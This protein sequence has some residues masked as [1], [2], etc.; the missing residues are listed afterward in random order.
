MG[1]AVVV[2]ANHY[3]LDLVG[4][5]A[6]VLFALWVARPTVDLSRLAFIG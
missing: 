6:L 1:L 4:G 2:T 3:V 5:L